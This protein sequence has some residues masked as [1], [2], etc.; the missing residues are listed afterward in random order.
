KIETILRIQ[1]LR[2]PFDSKLV[3]L[4]SDDDPIVRRRAT[5]AYG[6]L[7]DTTQISL[8]THNLTTA[9]EGTEQAAAFAL[10]QTGIRLSEKGRRDLEHDLI[11]NRLAQS[12]AAGRMIEEIGKFG[13]ENGLN[14]LMIRFGNAPPVPYPERLMMCIARYAIR[15]IVSRDAVRFLLRYVQPGNPTPWQAIYALQRIG[16]HPDTRVYIETIRLLYKDRD[17]LVRMNLAPLLGKLR[18]KEG[19]HEVLLRMAEFD[20]DWR[21]R[22]NAYKALG[23]F[24]W[25]GSSTVIAAFRRA[26]YDPN[27]HVSIAAISALPQTGITLTDSDATVHETLK[28]LSYI[29]LNASGGFPWQLQAEAAS[30]LAQ[31]DGEI[32]P[33]LGSESAEIY[34]KL[35]ARLLVA[36]GESG[37][38]QAA[39]I[40]F[41][42]A[43]DEDAEVTCAALDGLVSLMRHNSHDNA[44]KDSV[45]ALALDELKRNDVAISAT[46]AS[47]LGDSLLLR[48]EAVAPLLDALSDLHPVHDSEAMLE[49]IA[50]LGKLNDARAVQPL[51]GLLQ[52]LDPGIALA[53]AAA[54]HSM[55]GDDY[56]GRITPKP[57]PITVDLDFAF[58]RA[59]P[60]VV[61]VTLKTSRG[62]IGL[63][64]FKNDAPFT[65][66]SIVKLATQRGFY[67]GLTFHRVVPNFVVQGGDPRGDGWGGP[68]YF[69]RSE[70]STETFS[71]G[72]VGMASAGK[73][74]EGSQFFIT[75]SPQPHLDGRYTVVGRVVSGMEVVD[76]L[77]VDDRIY[78]LALG[79]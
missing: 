74:T 63:E 45:F 36:S 17:P 73:D 42:A 46:S 53:A 55:T 32:P 69:L 41:K 49:V 28:E 26:M 7:Q 19:A 61:R 5:L 30:A 35:R 64:L 31:I 27:P 13:T 34:P 2:T 1:D 48:T 37:K 71:T 54:L 40:L 22:V 43:R 67:R 18:D 66:M 65:T 78:D 16:D 12:A 3:A 14:D 51:I 38:A 29:A 75:H 44:L 68:E 23:T 79:P 58:L 15:G 50:T 21:V 72:T 25:A 33:A 60:D 47:M 24:P 70:F 9:D 56:A 10:G 57:E 77:Q 59:L 11:W 4:L 39:R 62:N 20:T 6:S 52:S 8:L 76:A